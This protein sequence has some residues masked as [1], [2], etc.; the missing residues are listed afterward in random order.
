MIDDD[1]TPAQLGEFA[2][3]ARMTRHFGASADCLLGPGDDAAV[4]AAPGRSVVACV[5]VL[6]DGRHFRRDWCTAE[7]VGHRAVAANLADIA[8]MG[9]RPTGLLVGVTTPPDLSV[10]WMEELAAGL[11]AEATRAGAFVAGGDTVSGRE[12]NISVT[13]LGDLEGRAPVTRGGAKPGDR[14]AMSG[15]LGWAAAGMTILSRGFRSPGA[16]VTAYRRPEVNHT[17]GPVAAALGAT[18]MI[19]ISDGLLSDVGHIAE[20]SA[21]S[22]NIETANLA[23]PETMLNAGQA[24]GVDPLAWVLTGGEDHALVA[25]FPPDML[26]GADWTVIGTV[27]SGT[28]VTVDGRRWEGATGWDHFS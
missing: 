12:L 5:D 23:I 25:T 27:D 19:D 15:R 21:V 7:D 28:S 6:V 3:I 9:A 16:L 8:A 17:A 4:V 14:L 10:A 24:M 13:A 18:A 26:L 1:A 20:A 22:I 11:S 2:T